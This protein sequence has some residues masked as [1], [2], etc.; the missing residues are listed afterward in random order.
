MK[1]PEI[2]QEVERNSSRDRIAR[3][4]AINAIMFAILNINRPTLLLL[5]VA[6]FLASTWMWVFFERYSYRYALEAEKA[7]DDGMKEDR[8]VAAA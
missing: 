7:L 1:A 6:L 4:T 3:G 5:S 2:S 8:D